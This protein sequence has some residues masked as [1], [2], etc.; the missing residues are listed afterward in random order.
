MITMKQRLE[1]SRFLE[2]I[3]E[4]ETV[5]ITARGS[6]MMPTFRSDMDTL[7]MSAVTPEELSVGDV[8]LFNRGDQ[9]CVH[10]IIEI[11]G[12]RL[13]LRGDGNP[14]SARE[15]ARVSDVFAR[16][17]G[18]TMHGGRPFRISDEQ[19]Q[20]A[21]KTAL[22]FHAVRYSSRLF[23]HRICSYPLSL[24][25][26]A[27]LLY[28]SFFD[29]SKSPVSNVEI[30]DKLVHFIMYLGVSGMFWTEWLS[31]HKG[32][33]G[34]FKAYAVCSLFPVL[35]G[36]LIEIAQEELTEVRG[37]DPLDFAANCAGVLC[38]LLLAL[39]VVKP[40]LVKFFQ[41]KDKHENQ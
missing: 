27:L 40:L 1:L 8:V 39:F 38:A 7:E 30:S 17:T 41:M 31:A 26:L 6:S 20:K 2:Y 19:W 13:V 36:G 21:T 23:I 25:V 28:L 14:K 32:R 3:S 18:G 12:D 22:Q 10:R 11:N 16:V 15:H 4:G 37:G 5:A 9:V 34:G 29:P 24:A 33:V 35:L